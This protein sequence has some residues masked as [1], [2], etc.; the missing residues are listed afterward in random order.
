MTTATRSK[1][2][3]IRPNAAPI[4]A[5]VVGVDLAEELDDESFGRIRDAYYRHSLLIVRDQDITPEQQISFTRRFGELRLHHLKQYVLPRHPEILVLSNIVE[6]GRTIGL[7]DPGRIAVWHTDLS[8]LR[9]P[10][11]GSTFYAVEIPH[12]DAGEALGDTLFASTFAAYDAL[13]DDMKKRLHGLRAIHRMTKGGYESGKNASASRVQY[14]DEHKKNFTDISHPIV[15]T[16]PV[17]GRKCIYINE[18]CTTGIEGMAD[19]DSAPLLAE[20]Y[21]H[22]TRPEFIYRHKW[23][24]GDLLMWDNCS[25][26]HLAIIDYALPQRRRM[27]RITL[28]GSIPF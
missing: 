18:L 22:C 9:E 13:S 15:R 26:L 24:K 20:L 23:R 27:H 12:D 10:V 7:A 5:E 21:V 11:A 6:N 19:S 17:T 14:S 16:H 28:K 4:G 3:S 8:Y 25:A 2:M 1:P